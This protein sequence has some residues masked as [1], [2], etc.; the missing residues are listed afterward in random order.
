[1]RRTKLLWFNI[2]QKQR[3]PFTAFFAKIDCQKKT[4]PNYFL[5]ISLEDSARSSVFGFSQFQK[6]WEEKYDEKDR[7]GEH[8]HGGG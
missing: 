2:L 6:G 8:E 1:M 3:C 7:G 4:E 5:A